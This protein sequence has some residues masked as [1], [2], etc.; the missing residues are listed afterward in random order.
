MLKAPDREPIIIICLQVIF[1]RQKCWIT[2]LLKMMMNTIK[3]LHQTI[4]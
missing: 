3:K 2:M 4:S 1:T